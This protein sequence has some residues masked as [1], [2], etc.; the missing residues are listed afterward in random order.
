MADDTHIFP[1]IR[2]WEGGYANNPND[3]GGETMAGVTYKLWVTLFGPDADDR[4]LAMSNED[5]ATCT[6]P[7]WFAIL[8]DKINSQRIADLMFDWVW[9]SGKYHPEHDVQHI[10]D[11]CFHNKLVEDGNFGPATIDAINSADE[12]QLWGDLVTD[13]YQYLLDCVTARPANQEFLHGWQNRMD[14][15]IKFES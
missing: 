5:W 2:K 12:Q 9:G 6:A 3:T 13:R 14:D 15:L 8:G 1:F 11:T 7:F 4:F 10:L